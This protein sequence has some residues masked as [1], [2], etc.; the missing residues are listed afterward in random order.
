MRVAWATD[1]HLNFLGAEAI[2]TFGAQVA[3]LTP[4]LFLVS[5]DIA[6]APSLRSCLEQLAQA[7]GV[8]THFVLGNHDFY[9]GSVEQVRDDMR[10]LDPAVGVW[11]PNAAPLRLDEGTVVVG[12]DGWG[13]A[14][15]GDPEGT[16][17]RLN[18]FVLIRELLCSSYA[19]LLGKLRACGDAEAETARSALKAA[20]QTGAE[21]IL[22]VTHVPPFRGACW[23]QGAVSNDEWLPFFTCQA[24]GSVLLEFANAHPWL[25]LTVL[26]GHTHGAGQLTLQPNLRV[27]TGAAE[28]GAP[29]VELLELA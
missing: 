26:C 3:A 25:R 2:D 21:H 22:F 20:L 24:I 15:L 19:E 28:Y 9:G 11:L 10:S 17:L 23:H 8:A 13:D 4:D 29:H 1:I 5:G 7:S 14:R 6:E 12:V 18:D 16:R 27:L